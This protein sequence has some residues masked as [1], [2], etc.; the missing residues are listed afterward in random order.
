M[1]CSFPASAFLYSHIVVISHFVSQSVSERLR[2]LIVPYCKRKM[3]QIV[4][5]MQILLVHICTLLLSI[6]F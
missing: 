3:W 4:V 5:I 2:L 6:L 1:F